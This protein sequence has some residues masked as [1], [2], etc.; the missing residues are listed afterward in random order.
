MMT[1]TQLAPASTEDP[2]LSAVC[3]R[4]ACSFCSLTSA[5][6]GCSNCHHTCTRCF[7][8]CRRLYGY[9]S[10]CRA[11]HEMLTRY[12]QRPGTACL[13]CEDTTNPTYVDPRIG[14]DAI[15]LRDHLRLWL[16]KTA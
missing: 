16:I 3:A 5:T 8:E 1:V 12:L 9:A 10:T 2:P 14:P 6:C 4:R 7:A 15:C 11:C 13:V